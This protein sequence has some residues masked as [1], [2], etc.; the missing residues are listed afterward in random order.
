MTNRNQSEKSALISFI[1]ANTPEPPTTNF[2]RDLGVIPI[3]VL[4]QVK[5]DMQ[6]KLN[7]K[8]R[9]APN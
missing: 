2:E 1:V 8:K 4:R 6:K 5:N 9:R 7:D 3:H